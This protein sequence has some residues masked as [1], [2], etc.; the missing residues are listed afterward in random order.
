MAAPQWIGAHN[1]GLRIE[2]EVVSQRTPRS[3]SLP[4]QR[5]DLLPQ[6]QV[7]EHE[8]RTRTAGCVEAT[9]DDRDQEHDDVHHEGEHRT[10]LGK[11]ARRI[12]ALGSN[13]RIWWLPRK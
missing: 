11:I 4:L 1:P 9:D 2:R 5:R 13:G 3:W 7:L 6:C 10:N 8:V 12:A